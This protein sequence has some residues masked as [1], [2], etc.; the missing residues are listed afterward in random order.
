MNFY[1]WHLIFDID[2][3]WHDIW[4]LTIDIYWDITRSTH[5]WDIARSIEISQDLTKSTEI[6]QDLLRFQKIY[7]F[8]ILHLIFNIWHLTLIRHCHDIWHLTLICHDIWHLYAMTF[9][10]SEGT[11]STSTDAYDIGTDGFWG[12]LQSQKK[13]WLTHSLTHWTI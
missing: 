1:F 9:D 10:I 11:D 5:Y 8:G 12:Y 13:H 3:P 2:T 7:W 4:H 6:S